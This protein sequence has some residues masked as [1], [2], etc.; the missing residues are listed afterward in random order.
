M[1]RT[2]YVL[3]FSAVLTIA[4][5]FALAQGNGGPVNFQPGPDIQQRYQSPT[6]RANATKQGKQ[7]VIGSGN[8]SIDTGDAK[9]VFWNEPLDLGGAGVVVNT[10]L[11]WDA[12]SKILYAFAQTTLR[13]TH[14]KP[15]NGNLLIGIYGKKNFLGKPPGA[16]W[17][18]AEL[19]QG[20]CQAPQAGIYGCK[21]GP[22]G[23]ALACGR[24]ELDPRVNDMA[25]VEAMRF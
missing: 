11:L 2:M 4:A 10:D 13:C 12:S 16:G 3:A 24:A 22:S 17:W 19:Q 14:G 25:I 21:F 8:A 20:E 6:P 18:V 7:A 9:N 5:T 1:N 15:V 23:Q